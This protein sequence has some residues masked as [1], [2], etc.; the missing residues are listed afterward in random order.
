MNRRG[1]LVIGGVAL[2]VAVGWGVQRSVRTASSAARAASEGGAGADG[3]A[4]GVSARINDS[5]A[6][7]VRAQIVDDDGEPLEGG[8]VSLRCLYDDEVTAIAGNAWKIDDDGAFEGPG[9][10]G[11]V[12]V[13]LHHA[14]AIP[15]EPWSLVPGEP[16]LLR[17]TTLPRLHGT[18]VDRRDRPIAAAR[19]TVRAPTDGEAEA[20]V[21]TIGTTT[22]TDVDGM[23][24]FALVQRP[25]CDP[26]T[27]VDRGCE[28]TPLLLHDRVLVGVH[29]DR[30]A[31]A[32]VEV[33]IEGSDIVAPPIRM[34]PPADALSGTLVD[35]AGDAYPRATIIARASDDPSEQHQTEIADG[36]FAFESLGAG[37]YD[38]RA[39]QDGLELATASRVKPGDDVELVG[40]QMARGPDI[41]LEITEDGLPVAGVTVDGGPF[42]G[43][44]TDVDGRVRADVAMPGE[45]MLSLRPPGAGLV[46][47]ALTI[48]RPAADPEPQ[49]DAPARVHLRVELDGDAHSAGRRR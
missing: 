21:P 29:A 33:E 34:T 37:P 45:H 30:F 32:R 5:A 16:G 2:A 4:A 18:V 1:A 20:T 31:P 23:F 27:E 12:C 35:P 43:A 48:P 40:S 8:H 3:D 7:R 11:I 25:P 39:L 9:C 10:L 47:R 14:T 15:A 42:R 19:V 36:G 38:L 26:C 28:D 24:S 6:R 49:P 17:A 44:R 22:T 13:E 46:R 41:E